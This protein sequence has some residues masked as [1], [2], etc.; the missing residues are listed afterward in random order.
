MPRPSDACQVIPSPAVPRVS[1]PPILNGSAPW[2]IHYTS[3]RR[4]R[5]QFAPA[6]RTLVL[7]HFGCR[8]EAAGYGFHIFFVAEMSRKR[9]R[10][11]T[12]I[13]CEYPPGLLSRCVGT[14]RTRLDRCNPPVRIHRI[15]PKTILDSSI[16]NRCAASGQ[17]LY[18]AAHSPLHR[19][20]RA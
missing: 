10:N 5:L 17:R 4:R 6:P 1:A 11:Q 3:L 2:V 20:G 16:E 13:P 8:S 12:H 7:D 9:K 15:F 18:R 19:E 14:A